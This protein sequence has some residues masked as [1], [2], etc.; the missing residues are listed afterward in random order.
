MKRFFR[1][2]VGGI[3][4]GVFLV[5]LALSAVKFRVSETVFWSGVLEKSG[6]YEELQSG[7]GEMMA[8]LTMD[9]KAVKGLDKVLTAEEIQKIIEINLERFLGFI[10]GG[11]KELV[12]FLPLDKLGLPASLLSRPP[13]SQLKGEVKVEVLL[14]A[15]MPTE[16][17]ETVLEQI[18]QIPGWW[19]VF[20]LV[21]G[22]LVV[23]LIL[24]GIG[25]Y[26]MGSTQMGKMKG[27]GTLLT[28][29]GLLAVVIALGASNGLRI[30]LSQAVA[31][32]PLVAKLIPELV[33]EFMNLGLMV[34]VVVAVVGIGVLVVAPRM[35]GKKNGVGKGK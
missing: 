14:R 7:A 16:Q 26:A 5:F 21:W 24:L 27:T 17:V 10:K 1:L 2:V 6:V 32:Q 29:S 3:F 31:T 11:E 23:L 18:N 22:G 34:G 25:H 13:F 15:S 12:L 28:V 35:V 30:V 19:R 4:V 8:G 33:S 9:K 20:G